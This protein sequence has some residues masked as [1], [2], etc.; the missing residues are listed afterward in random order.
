MWN[1][2][3]LLESF[4]PV[5]GL[6]RVVISN[7]MTVQRT[8]K[9]FQ[10][11]SSL[12]LECSH[13]SPASERTAAPC[14]SPQNIQTEVRAGVGLK[15]SWAAAGGIEESRMA[16]SSRSSEKGGCFHSSKR[17]EEKQDFRGSTIYK[18]GRN[19][20]R[21]TK[22]PKCSIFQAGRQIKRGSVFKLNYLDLN[23][24]RHLKRAHE[25]VHWHP[26]QTS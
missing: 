6:F 16:V 21:N 1:L 20:L 11:I 4:S 14:G 24:A 13:L 15:R 2:F 22:Y 19:S 3:S 7:S 17:R 12:W 10:L 5:F 26:I 8:F 25:L 9:N 23:H 18:I